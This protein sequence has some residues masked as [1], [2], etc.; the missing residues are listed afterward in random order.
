MV[1]LHVVRVSQRSAPSQFPVF[2]QAPVGATAQVVGVVVWGEP[3]MFEQLPRPLLPRVQLLQ[4]SVQW[5]VQQTCSAEQNPLSQS[6]SALHF[7]P[8]INLS[9]Q[10]LFVMRQVSLFVQSVSAEQVVRQVGLLVGELQTYDPH[11]AVAG[12]GHTP[13]PSQVAGKVWM[14]EVQLSCR[15]PVPLAHGRQA[16]APLQVP[17]REQSPLATSPFLQRDLTSAWP[18]STN[19]HVPAGPAWV[20][21]QDMHKP[22]GEASEHE[23]LQHTPS[24]QNP[25]KHW[26]AAVHAAPFTFRPQLL[27]AQVVGE[28]QSVSFVQVVLQAPESQMKLPQSIVLGV[29]QV[30]L[31]SQAEA[32]VAE[33]VLAQAAALQIV[34]LG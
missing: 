24:V 11:D 27:F 22:L 9:P 6:V 2:P 34:P 33:D 17:S 12:G 28:R 23:V 13:L 7:F 3:A 32:A 21:L 18:L 1:G 29:L 15:Q 31:P 10:V 14:A 4:P 5:S 30:P 26:V 25:L 16:P 8:L 19:E 20:P